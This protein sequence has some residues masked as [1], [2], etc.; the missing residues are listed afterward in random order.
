MMSAV[1]REVAKLPETACPYH[2]DIAIADRSQRYG[3]ED[4]KVT[5]IR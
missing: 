5:T 2:D 3:V 4:S 1:K